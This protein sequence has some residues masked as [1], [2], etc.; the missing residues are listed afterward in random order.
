[1]ILIKDRHFSGFS[2]TSLLWLGKYDTSKGSTQRHVDDW[3]IRV[4]SGKYDTYKGST[5]EYVPANGVI[6]DREIW[7]L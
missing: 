6:S 5:L 1:M 7:Y 2:I 4:D 3:Y